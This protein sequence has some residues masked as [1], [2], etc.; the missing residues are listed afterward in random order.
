MAPPQSPPRRRSS[1]S[2]STATPRWATLPSISSSMGS[3]GAWKQTFPPSSRNPC[4]SSTC[5]AFRASTRRN[6]AVF[7]V[8]Q[9]PTNVR[10]NAV[11]SPRTLPAGV[12]GS[13]IV[14]KDAKLRAIWWKGVVITAGLHLPPLEHLPSPSTTAITRAATH[15]VPRITPQSPQE[16]GAKVL[17]TWSQTVKCSSWSTLGTRS[18]MSSTNTGMNSTAMRLRADVNHQSPRHRSRF[19]MLMSWT[20]AVYELLA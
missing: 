20:H 15:S 13:S 2:P 8:K 11:P 7:A 1:G 16:K 12:A 3:I 19:P 5:L 6:W 14:L 9:A 18:I 17:D 4:R 10:K